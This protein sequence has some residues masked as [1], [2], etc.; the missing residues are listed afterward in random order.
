[1]IR[2]A[3]IEDAPVICDIY[4]HYVANTIITFEET[5]VSVEE[6]QGRIEE[7]TSSFPWYVWQEDRILGEY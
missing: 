7:V 4:N 6:M 3:T 1:M 5:P 2:D